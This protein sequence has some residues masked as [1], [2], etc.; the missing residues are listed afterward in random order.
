MRCKDGRERNKRSVGMNR[1]YS[2][3]RRNGKKRH[4]EKAE[5]PTGEQLVAHQPIV[6]DGLKSLRHPKDPS[7]QIPRGMTGG[8]DSMSSFFRIVLISPKQSWSRPVWLLSHTGTISTPVTRAQSWHEFA[9]HADR[10]E[11]PGPN[12]SRPESVATWTRSF[13]TKTLYTAMANSTTKA[14]PEFDAISSTPSPSSLD[15][16]RVYEHREH[17]RSAWPIV[18]F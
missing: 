16:V 11:S 7:L 15:A 6:G 9:S 13:P 12:L 10:I 14:F 3:N 18:R 8:C 1:N 17:G 2:R 4:F 5:K